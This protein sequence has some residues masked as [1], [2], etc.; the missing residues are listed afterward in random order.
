MGAQG[1]KKYEPYELYIFLAQMKMPSFEGR[2]NHYKLAT[3]QGQDK[4]KEKCIML[5]EHG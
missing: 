3:L 4:D 5:S 2:E 1:T